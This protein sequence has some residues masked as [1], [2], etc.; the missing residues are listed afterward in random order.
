VDAGGK[1]E[2]QEEGGEAPYS[3][4]IRAAVYPLFGLR[5][6]AKIA[7]TIGGSA[8]AIVLNPSLDCRDSAHRAKTSNRRI[9]N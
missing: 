9:G 1:I 7:A 4:A 6:P 5:R 8:R 3:P 2:E